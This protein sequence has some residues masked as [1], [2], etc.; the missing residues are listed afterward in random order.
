METLK[1]IR[2]INLLNRKRIDPGKFI[3]TGDP[4][5]EE[6][7]I[8]Q[9]KYNREECLENNSISP[10][11]L[12]EFGT[13]NYNYWLNVYGLNDPDTIASVCKKQGIHT[14]AIQDIL[15]INQRP[16]FQEFESFSFLTLKSITPA[17]KDMVTEQISFVFGERYLISFQE[18]KADYFNHIRQ[19]LRDDLGIIRERGS[20]FLLY[21]MLEAI[22]D[23]YFRTIT[24]LDN[25][26]G[27]LNLTD[28]RKMSS[29]D[30]LGI[31]ENHKKFVHFVKRSI[32]PIKEFTLITER[33]ESKFIQKRHLKYFLEIKDLCLTLVESCD[34]LL[35]SLES[36]TNLFFSIQGHRMNQIMK[37]LT[38]VATIFIPLTFI[39]GIYGMNFSNMPEMKWRYGYAMVWLIIVLVSLGMVIYFRN[40]KW[41]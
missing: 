3:Y 14:L 33:E 20:D 2:K 4:R 36:N 23:N 27:N 31:I 39:V 15:D 9:F 37:T 41:F 32:L 7:E 28:M 19:R 25:E 29:P 17:D 34:A 38:I 8:S 6:I 10:D 35:S 22:L 30:V 26:I 16:K 1:K 12:E 24:L 5:T 11:N 40:K 18:R 21:A 13:G